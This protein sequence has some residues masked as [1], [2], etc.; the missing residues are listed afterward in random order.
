MQSTQ[1]S[2]VIYSANT[3]LD[4]PFKR[5]FGNGETAFYVIQSFQKKVGARHSEIRSLCLIKLSSEMLQN[6][7]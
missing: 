1:T 3:K 7:A 6:M 4:G 5:F 2:V